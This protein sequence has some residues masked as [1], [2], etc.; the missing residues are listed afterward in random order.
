LESVARAR[1]HAEL[2]MV[3][4]RAAK[5]YWS[6]YVGFRPRLTDRCPTVWTVF[7]GRLEKRGAQL[8]PRWA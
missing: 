5:V 1:D 3:E 6:R 4:A 7:R 2:L 8:V